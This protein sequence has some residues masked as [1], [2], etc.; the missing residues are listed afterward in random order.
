[1]SSN[2]NTLED[3]ADGLEEA[4]EQI[5]KASAKDRLGIVSGIYCCAAAISSSMKGW[6]N[7]LSNPLLMESYEKEEL[8]K[9]YNMF[10]DVAVTLLEEDLKWTKRKLEDALASE[11]N[12]QC[13]TGTGYIA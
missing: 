13:N 1:M 5:K 4:L 2:N 6:R 7:W 11:K 10:K 9:L 12:D 3:W 8:D